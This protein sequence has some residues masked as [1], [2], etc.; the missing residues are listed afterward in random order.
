M[1]T[2]L[3]LPPEAEFIDRARQ[4][5]FEHA[6]LD[7]PRSALGRVYDWLTAKRRLPEEKV[8]AE[9]LRAL[10][11][12]SAIVTWGITWCKTG[13]DEWRTPFRK[14]VPD[15]SIGPKSKGKYEWHD[16]RDS[17]WL[18]EVALLVTFNPSEWEGL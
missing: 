14:H 16:I 11:E 5:I 6:D 17:E 7:V 15:M 3:P 9:T 8:D 13:P 10:P 2:T 18:A 1:S 4:A 12:G